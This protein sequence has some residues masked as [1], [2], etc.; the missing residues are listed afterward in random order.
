MERGALAS[1]Y[2]EQRM[3]YNAQTYD[4]TIDYANAY[5]DRVVSSIL[6]GSA[7]L[8]SA[9]SQ[10]AWYSDA[11]VVYILLDTNICMDHLGSD[12]G[13]TC[14]LLEIIPHFAQ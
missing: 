13:D 14:C 7:C 5:D 6:Q 10:P 2:T 1:K 3:E 12:G 11:L 8:A 9:C 4:T